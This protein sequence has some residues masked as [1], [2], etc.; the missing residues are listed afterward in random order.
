MWLW[1]FEH[2][3]RP[4]CLWTTE[5]T[6]LCLPSGIKV[7]CHHYC[8]SLDFPYCLTVLY[9]NPTIWAILQAR[10]ANTVFNKEIILLL[11]PSVFTFN[12]LCSL[13]TQTNQN[14]TQERK[15]QPQLSVPFHASTAQ[16]CPTLAWVLHI[17]LSAR[18]TRSSLFFSMATMSV[19]QTHRL[20]DILLPVTQE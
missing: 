16:L 18:E 11:A 8:N 5:R 14:G 9:W 4:G 6:S 17:Q 1:W 20:T 15:P 19:Q 10:T 12:G 3:Y 7:V 2:P 13:H